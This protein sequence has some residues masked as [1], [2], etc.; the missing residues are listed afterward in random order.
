MGGGKAHEQGKDDD[1]QDIAFHQRL[2]GIGGHEAQHRIPETGDLSAFFHVVNVDGSLGQGGHLNAATRLENLAGSQAQSHSHRR[3]DTVV[4][5]GQETNLPGTAGFSKRGSP[6]NQGKEHQGH[7]DHL[8]EAHEEV[9]HRREHLGG[10]PHDKAH[11]SAEH[12]GNDDP[13][14]Q[15]VKVG[16][17]FF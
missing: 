17:R 2:E 10:W 6:A 11:H 9:A 16:F 15:L 1:L 13:Q 8:D 7:N 4:A 12:R 14:A 5:K 3:G